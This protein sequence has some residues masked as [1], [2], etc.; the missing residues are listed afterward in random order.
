MW[1]DSIQVKV[2]GVDN[3]VAKAVIEIQQKYP[4][5]FGMRLR[6]LLLGG[7]YVEDLYIYPIPVPAPG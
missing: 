3:P 4:S 7:V 5:R 6:N 1:L 2:A